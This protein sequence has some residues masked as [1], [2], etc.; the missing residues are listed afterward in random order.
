MTEIS[1]IVLLLLK[2]EKYDRQ[3]F[4][5]VKI[6]FSAPIIGEKNLLLYTIQA[7]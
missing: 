1:K 5:S 4:I 3:A 6:G 7:I 2:W